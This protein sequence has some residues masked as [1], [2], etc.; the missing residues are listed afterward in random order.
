MLER[1]VLELQ[2]TTADPRLDASCN[3]RFDICSK[4]RLGHLNT[5]KRVK[6]SQDLVILSARDENL[7]N[8]LTKMNQAF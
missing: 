3:E 5:R 7:D 1:R 2:S 8:R 4:H 6:T